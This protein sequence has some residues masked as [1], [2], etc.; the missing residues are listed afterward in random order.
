MRAYINRFVKHEAKSVMP[1][2]LPGVKLR[3]ELPTFLSEFQWVDLRKF[4]N[5]NRE[6]LRNL[7]AGIFGRRPRDLTG[8]DLDMVLLTDLRKGAE[9]VTSRGGEV[10]TISLR[11]NKKMDELQELDREAIR[12][13]MADEIGISSAD[14][15]F[16]D[17]KPGSAVVVLKI[18]DMKGVARLFAM[19]EQGDPRILEFFERCSIN[20]NDF[21]EDNKE[22]KGKVRPSTLGQGQVFQGPV[23]VHG[24]LNV[25]SEDRSVEAGGNIDGSAVATG[26]GNRQ[27][28]HVTE[29]SDVD[30]KRE[31]SA[32]RQAIEGLDLDAVVQRHV[33]RDLEN[34]E[35]EVESEGPDKSYVDNRVAGA[36]ERLE[37]AGKVVSSLTALKTAASAVAVWCS[38]NAE[39]LGPVLERLWPG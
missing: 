15:E 2:L 28:L 22:V 9:Q 38:V 6:P 32:V 30:I 31:L 3:P 10:T 25:G 14:V 20:P 7:V 39:K 33:L 27:E 8:W 12:A 1:V 4:A 11:V 36:L 19:A 13:Q 34:A 17:L 24:N 16:V 26:D 29:G 23:T 21:R 35:A 37:K 5:R 18:K